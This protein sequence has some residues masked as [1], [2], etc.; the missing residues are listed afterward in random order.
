MPAS[1]QSKLSSAANSTEKVNLYAEAGL[2]YDALG[3]ALK[4]AEASKLGT[5]GA[6]LINDLAQSEAPRPELSPQERQAIEKQIA[7]LQQIAT[8]AR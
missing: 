1:V 5:L 2:W 4:Q 8:S 7:I 3:E 6:T